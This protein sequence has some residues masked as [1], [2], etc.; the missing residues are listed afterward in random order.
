MGGFGGGERSSAV[1]VLHALHE[2]HVDISVL[3]LLYHSICL[4]YV[5]VRHQDETVYHAMSGQ[6]LPSHVD[7]RLSG[8]I[9]PVKDQGVYSG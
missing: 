6:E 9:T 4:S 3:H 2:S 5:H 8:A 7:W 1:S